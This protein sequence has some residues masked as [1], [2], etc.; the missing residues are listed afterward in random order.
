MRSWLL[1]LPILAGCVTEPEGV[2]PINVR[3]IQ[4]AAEYSIWAAELSECSG[5]LVSPAQISWYA[6]DGFEDLRPRL[7]F[8]EHPTVI[9]GRW[10]AG[11]I[12]I[13]KDY[14]L[15]STVIKHELNHERLS[16]DMRHLDS[17][18]RLCN[19]NSA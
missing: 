14:L 13:H 16:G 15:N 10:K 11:R 8:V 12:Y 1:L 4:P 9:A 7:Q 2:I 6:V 19:A 17:S 18:W 3:S 5:S